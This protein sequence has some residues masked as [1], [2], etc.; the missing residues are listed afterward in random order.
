MKSTYSYVKAPSWCP[1]A[2]P[3]R[4]G[5]RHPKTGELLVSI[6]GGLPV[7]ESV[8]SEKVENSVISEKIDDKVI[9]DETVHSEKTLI[10]ESTQEKQVIKEEAAPKTAKP[11]AA[12]TKKEEKNA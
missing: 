9:L 5:W 12:R 4:Q 2:V 6:P 1:D 7:V 11:R 8:I 3:T 10:D